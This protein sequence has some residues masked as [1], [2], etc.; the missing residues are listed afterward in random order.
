MWINF[1]L[2]KGG[3][4]NTLSPQAI[5]TGISP[6]TEKHCTVPFGANVQVHAD[7]SQSS[8]N[9]MIS[10]TVG[11]IS[12]GST[13]NIQG[14]YKFMSFLTGK[15]IKARSFT[16]L[17]MS[18]NVITQIERMGAFNYSPEYSNAISDPMIIH[19][20][21]KPPS[22]EDDVS[23]ASNDN[24]KI[25]ESELNDINQEENEVDSDLCAPEIVISNN[26]ILTEA[27]D[28]S[29]DEAP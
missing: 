5:V 11:M 2:P 9:A 15:I 27:P 8:S 1:F 14:T 7:N 20:E 28:A 22:E 13:G 17:Q 16:P 18:D 25:I 24:S 29:L 23:F 19:E 6:N 26:N 21:Y 10:R 4:S 12:L 3:I